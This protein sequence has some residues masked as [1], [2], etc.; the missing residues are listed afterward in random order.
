M[1]TKDGYTG[2]HAKDFVRPWTRTVFRGRPG[3]W[4]ELSRTVRVFAMAPEGDDAMD[5]W[6]VWPCELLTGTSRRIAEKFSVQVGKDR[7]AAYE[8]LLRASESLDRDEQELCLAA[9]NAWRMV[10][11][12]QE[13]PALPILT[14]PR[15]GRWYDPDKRIPAK[16]FAVTVAWTGLDGSRHAGDRTAFYKDGTWHWAFGEQDEIP[17]GITVDAWRACPPR[18]PEWKRG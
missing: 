9:E 13:E 12:A 18:P 15:Q 3:F 1:L 4:I 2:I 5:A 10:L 14:E 6:R 11:D 8:I 16:P 17:F 7:D